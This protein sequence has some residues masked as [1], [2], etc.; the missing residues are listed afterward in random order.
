MSGSATKF[1]KLSSRGKLFIL[2]AVILHLWI[3]LLLKVIPFRRIPT[4]FSSKQP[5]VSSL[6]SES[7]NLVRV[8][9]QR[10]GR[11]SPW[12]NRCLVSSLVARK[13]L[14]RRHIQSSLSLGVAKS[15][16]GR[17]VAHA[18]LSSGEEE[19]TGKHGDYRELFVF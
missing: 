7:I 13:M 4:L 1:M 17:T 9:I 5:S 2:E 6:Q 12:R 15:P 8:A 10:G 18:W 11:V 19:V 3:G 16:D 14:N